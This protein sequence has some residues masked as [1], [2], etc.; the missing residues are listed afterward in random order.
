MPMPTCIGVE[1]GWVEASVIAWGAWNTMVYIL[2]EDAVMPVAPPVICYSLH[3][4]AINVE[5]AP[6]GV[7]HG[8]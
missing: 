5:H 3:N 4:A 6:L 2:C 1:A 7:N 8:L